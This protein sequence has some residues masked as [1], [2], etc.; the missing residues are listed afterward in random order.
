MPGR[1]RNK[2]ITIDLKLS[3]TLLLL[4][5]HII[6]NVSGFPNQCRNHLELKKGKRNVNNS[7]PARYWQCDKKISKKAWYR[8]SG[9]AGNI[10]TSM[11]VTP[12][13]CGSTNP[14]WLNG[15]HPC[16]M[17]ETKTGDVC[18]VDQH[19]DCGTRVDI[20]IT[21]CG[22]FYVYQL[23]KMKNC[24]KGMGSFCGETSK[25]PISSCNTTK[26]SISSS[27]STT[28]QSEIEQRSTFPAGDQRSTFAFTRSEGYPKSTFPSTTRSVRIEKHLAKLEN[29][30]DKLYSNT[31]SEAS[32]K[33]MAKRIIHQLSNITYLE[34]TNGGG[35]ER[36]ESV[37]VYTVTILQKIVDLNISDSSLDVLEPANYVLHSSYANSWR[38]VKEKNTIRK[39]IITLKNYG[40]QNGEN[41]KKN[42]NAS[43]FFIFKNHSNVQLY[44]TYAQHTRRLSREGRSFKFPDATFKLS[45]DAL[46]KHSGALVVVIWFKT[47]HSFLNDDMHNPMITSNM[48]SASV[49]PEPRT[50]FKR[51]VRIR[52]DMKELN[53]STTCVYWKPERKES[54]WETSG[55]VRVKEKMKNNLL[56]C[57]CDHLTA[58]AAMDISRDV[59]SK[60]ERQALEAISTV[61]CSLSLLAIFLTIL[62]HVLLWKKLQQ[63]SKSEIPSRVLMHLCVAIGMTDIMAILA[64]PARSDETFCISVSIL[65]YFFVL[66]AFGWMLC[67]G[68]IIYLQLV[69][70]YTGLGL[71]GRHMKVFYIIGW[72]FPVVVVSFLVALNNRKD[73]IT[74]H[75]CWCNN[76]GALFWVFVSTMILILLINFVIFILALRS[77]LSSSE[78]STTRSLSKRVG[79]K[80]S[81][82]ASAGVT[83]RKAKLGLKGTAIL[84][85]LLGLTWVFG[86]LVF[87]RDTIVFKY[88]F[89]IFNSIQGLMIFVFHVLINRKIHDAIIKGK[90]TFHATHINVT[91]LNNNTCGTLSTSDER[92]RRKS[93]ISV[94]PEFLQKT[95]SRPLAVNNT[96]TINN[97]KYKNNI[98]S[99]NVIL[100]D[101]EPMKEL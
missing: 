65:L 95:L 57:E 10:I 35:N 30:A 89:A 82:K 60:A 71:G 36:K 11:A 16:M 4:G 47:M 66:A 13:M 26:T 24:R 15:Q 62:A 44:A 1:R 63:N 98:N 87:N 19:G 20:S 40:F 94:T 54:N 77:A 53:D 91:A 31:I 90:K 51:P 9:D 33:K 3:I 61:G 12:G 75:A 93:S 21:H 97:N 80:N 8:F 92:S 99:E 83:L 42:P 88:L 50:K 79:S 67:E 37:L 78:V 5:K 69:N 86:L 7:I 23:P 27:T 29:E 73:F 58:F 64:G 17:N 76:D 6:V 96:Y 52:W 41:I 25:I 74:E 59:E 84:L 72:G 46:P 101:V 85:P 45:S 81:I 68:A 56:I 100:E 43:S 28:K 55:C 2:T 38:Q 39:M 14:G 32:R 18:F 48:I 34:I 49:R 22:E 70:V